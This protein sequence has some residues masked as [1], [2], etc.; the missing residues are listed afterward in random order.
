MPTAKFPERTALQFELSA[1]RT[2]DE[3]AALFHRHLQEQ[4]GPS[5]GPGQGVN[6]LDSA[7]VQ[8]AGWIEFLL[9]ESFWWA[10]EETGIRCCT[11]PA[12][13]NLKKDAALFWHQPPQQSLLGLSGELFIDVVY[14]EAASS[15]ENAFLEKFYS[16][17][18]RQLAKMFEA[19]AG[20]GG[21]KITAAISSTT[22]FKG[23][24]EQAQPDFAGRLNW[25][26]FHSVAGASSVIR[27]IETGRSA[28]VFSNA[29]FS[30]A[31][32]ARER[33]LRQHRMGSVEPDV[34]IS[35]GGILDIEYLAAA[36]QMAFGRKIQ[37]DVRSPDTLTALYG[38][39]QAG[40]IGEKHYQDLRAA[41]V[42]L[43]GLEEALRLLGESPE[44]LQK[45]PPENTP[46]FLKTARL[47]GYQGP[48]THIFSEFKLACQHH[49]AAAERLYEFY[50]VNLANQPW[51]D[52]TGQV[53]VTRESVRVRLDEL[54][55]GEPRPEDVPALRRMGFTDMGRLGKRFQA[56]CPNMTA[57]EP[58]SHVMEK[59]WELWPEI[60]NPDLALDHL[61]QFLAQNDDPYRLWY[62]LAKSDKG[63][64]LL[65]NLFGTSRSLS[66]L[67]LKNRGCWPWVEQ[68]QLLSSAQ[69]LDE[70]ESAGTQETFEKLSAF[71]NREWLRLALADFFMGESFEK[72]MQAYSR[73]LVYSVGQLGA[74][75]GNSGA[76]AVMGLDGLAGG[77]HALTPEWN[78]VLV[79]TPEAGAAA[80]AW[81]EKMTGGTAGEAWTQLKAP[82][83]NRE[84][85][86]L[87]PVSGVEAYFRQM[88]DFSQAS[89]WLQAGCLAGDPAVYRQAIAHLQAAWRRPACL[90]KKSLEKTLQL[91]HEHIER[92]LSR[93]EE[94]LSLRYA[95][96][97]F[98]DAAL[99]VSLAWSRRARGEQFEPCSLL[100]MLQ[101]A[102]QSKILNEEE[103]GLLRE[104]FL[105]YQKMKSRLWFANGHTAGVLPHDPEE[106]RRTAKVMGFR[107]QG[108]DA[109]E[110]R[111]RRHWDRL[112]ANVLPLF[113][114]IFQDTLRAL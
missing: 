2:F 72:L 47:M 109:A 73:L 9:K 65:L 3:R 71:K 33:V 57:F 88:D 68:T 21:F 97:G 67:F 29:P 61:K 104:A 51:E 17:F 98:D 83:H 81:L 31:D 66:L 87:L 114:R 62:A 32:A 53:V 4:A 26:K 37:G 111:F 74:L 46:A 85:I 96:G 15:E 25:L 19:P 58:F 22:V 100:Q 5:H 45:L 93:H 82:A 44:G 12:E 103:T 50:M 91:R 49:M 64:R 107:D 101:T 35:P 89:S 54:L 7:G 112:R 20:G 70:L 94:N 10:F 27:E 8:A 23:K 106:F 59:S 24:L 86:F 28:L 110:A 80:R 11:T 34:R 63:L 16:E 76:C 56:L 41:Y 113:E 18:C 36:L 55:L 38:L 95:A 30:F 84:P 39:W 60:P 48:D 77:A 69:T 99:A 1:C 13:A 105:E 108:I 52:I 79:H 102:A 43:T 40:V 78:L 90:E 42:F 75:T 92:L 14:H 6:F